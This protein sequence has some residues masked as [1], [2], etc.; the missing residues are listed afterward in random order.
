MI[1]DDHIAFVNRQLSYYKRRAAHP[2][3]KGGVI[4]PVYQE[5]VDKLEALLS[6]L[7]SIKNG[8]QNVL[9]GQSDIVSYPEDKLL[10]KI[11]EV[12][13]KA[14]L[15]ASFF[16]DTFEPT[17][18]ELFSLP[19]SFLTNSLGKTEDDLL[20]LKIIEMVQM[21]GTISL[22]KI[23]VGLYML[24]GVEHSRIKIMQRAYKLIRKGYIYSVPN[25]KGVYSSTPL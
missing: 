3:K 13:T 12:N 17:A 15:P 22:S 14:S 8:N 11:E 2:T 9:C 19:V 5:S 21:A 18:S 24:T 6:F 25:K 23:M 10:P 7:I 20:D 1:V 4:P 16:D